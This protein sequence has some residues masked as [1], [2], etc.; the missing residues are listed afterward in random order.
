[1]RDDSIVSTCHISEDLGKLGQGQTGDISVT[2]KD[3]DLKLIT[4][5][6]D[7]NVYYLPYS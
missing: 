6:D 5:R 2:T 3:T 7:V 1:M 4:N